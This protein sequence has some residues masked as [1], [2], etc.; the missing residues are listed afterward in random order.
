MTKYQLPLQVPGV[1][2]TIPSSPDDP[3][4]PLRSFPRQAAAA[5]QAFAPSL[6]PLCLLSLYCPGLWAQLLRRVKTIEVRTSD[7]S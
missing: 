1:P 2:P 5:T 7:I 4:L 6:H 3:L